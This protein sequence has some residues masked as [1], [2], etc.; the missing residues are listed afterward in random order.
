[1]CTTLTLS[2]THTILYLIYFQWMHVTKMVLRSLDIANFENGQLCTAVLQLINSERVREISL[3]SFFFCLSVAAVLFIAEM[4]CMLVGV[5][6]YRYL[7]KCDTGKG[8]W[9]FY[10]HVEPIFV[11]DSSC[12]IIILFCGHAHNVN[13]WFI[14]CTHFLFLNMC[15]CVCMSV[16]LYVCYTART[17]HECL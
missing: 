2:H 6:F 12:V 17:E 15:D 9:P 1:M 14:W 5:C 10:A 7:F 4:L 16:W 11:H 13:R 8:N 3:L